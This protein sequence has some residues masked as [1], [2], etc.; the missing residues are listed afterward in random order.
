MP[1]NRAVARYYD[2]TVGLY[3]MWFMSSGISAMHYGIADET[4]HSFGESLRNTN[5]YL[6]TQAGIIATDTVLDAGCGIGGSSLWLAE[7]IGCTATGISLSER[8]IQHAK[9]LAHK[10]RQEQKV[11][12]L[13]GDY[14]KTGLPDASFD[15]V[16]GLE[17]VC[18]A[19]DKQAFFHEA[20]RLLK[21][22]GR[23]VVG[24]GFMLREPKNDQEKQWTKRFEK[25]F[26]V[27]PLVLPSNFKK[28][29]ERAGFTNVAFTDKTKNVWPSCKRM[30]AMAVASYPLIILLRSLHLMESFTHSH[31]S[32]VT[33]YHC[34]KAGVYGYGVFVA[35]KP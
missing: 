32:G 29:L 6:A 30:Y 2:D 13:V 3:R 31:D 1:T 25:G 15:V 17:S 24:D 21:P 35:H 23:L 14:T 28:G 19:A 11:S 4:T 8:Q 34:V 18:H 10:R 26:V 27:P 12:Y 9:R 5:R 33:Q 7:N 22:G 20:Y 16:W